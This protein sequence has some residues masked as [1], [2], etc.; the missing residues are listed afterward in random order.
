[1]NDNDKKFIRPETARK[2]LKVSDSTLKRWSVGRA[3]TVAMFAMRTQS[4]RDKRHDSGKLISIRTTGTNGKNGHR[5]YNIQS[6]LDNQKHR[7]QYI[8]SES[9]SRCKYTEQP[10]QNICYARVSTRSQ[11]ED[12]ERQINYFREKYPNHRI[13][14][15]I[16]SGLN[17]KRKGLQTILDIAIKGNLGEL[18]VTHKD[19]LCGFGFEL[20]QGIT[21]KYSNGKI[22]VLDKKE[23]SPEQELSNDLISII[24]VFSARVAWFVVKRYLEKQRD[25]FTYFHFLV[26][27]KDLLLHVNITIKHCVL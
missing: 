15:D 24:T 26:L 14:N 20:I 13:I 22:L 23:T 10:K 16:G 8:P 18:V 7:K 27:N 19:R 17:F 12:L 25:F 1:M 4:Q 21:E 3:N 9:H 11:K 6:I 5:R 2:M